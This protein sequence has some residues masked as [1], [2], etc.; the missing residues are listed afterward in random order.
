MNNIDNIIRK[1]YDTIIIFNDNLLYKIFYNNIIN[2]S[3][4]KTVI[5]NLNKLD[6]IENLYI[7]AYKLYANNTCVKK[8]TEENYKQTYL[9]KFIESGNFNFLNIPA[10]EIYKYDLTYYDVY[11]KPKTNILSWYYQLYTY[12]HLELNNFLIVTGETGV[13]KSVFLPII[14]NHYNKIKNNRFK[15]IILEPSISNIENI[16][17]GINYYDNTIKIKRI[18]SSVEEDNIDDPDIF[19]I[20]YGSYLNLLLSDDYKYNIN[21]RIILAD[22]IHTVDIN[23]DIVMTLLKYYNDLDFK[24]MISSATLDDFTIKRY[25]YVFSKESDIPLILKYINPNKPKIYTIMKPIDNYTNQELKNAIKNILFNYI[26]QDGDILIFQ[27]SAKHIIDLV[28]YLNSITPSN[29]IALPYYSSLPDKTKQIIYNFNENRNKII[30]E[31]NDN[32]ENLEIASFD[33]YKYERYIIVA[34]NIIEASVTIRTLKYV[35]DDGKQITLKYNF[36]INDTELL[37]TD[38]DN[39]SRLQRT[40]RVGRITDGTVFYLYD[41]NK[42]LNHRQ[43]HAIYITNLTEMLLRLLIYKKITIDDIYDNNG[44]FYVF[45]PDEEYIIRDNNYNKIIGIIK[46]NYYNIEFINNKII[47][48][49]MQYYIDTITKLYLPNL[50]SIGKFIEKYKI[51]ISKIHKAHNEFFIFMQILDTLYSNKINLYKFINNFLYDNKIFIKYY[52]Y[53]YNFYDNDYN[54]NKYLID[55]LFQYI[56]IRE[57]GENYVNIYAYDISKTYKLSNKLKK[58][59][60]TNLIIVFNKTAD[61]ILNAIP[62][63]DDDLKFLTYEYINKRYIKS[64]IVKNRLLKLIK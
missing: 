28:N 44:T 45:H 23:I 2:D 15:L 5:S 13:G 34:T 43:T 20:T 6:V 3:L 26:L 32:L 21:N 30:S 7:F 63:F 54:I 57:F 41:I 27:P 29:T 47:S 56:F 62:I 55:I 10:D 61:E 17:D 9:Y 36:K 49:K 52:E 58:L 39:S 35:I 22:E 11:C 37:L 31:K 46:P 60:T 40:G 24:L 64:D 50:I 19:L 4:I 53:Y 16:R 33:V 18:Y 51:D 48:E 25:N 8:I 38:I 14:L 59:I 42:I 1:I 12:Y